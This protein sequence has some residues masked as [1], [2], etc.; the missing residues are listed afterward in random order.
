ML[1]GSQGVLTGN[2]ELVKAHVVEEHIDATEVVGG[3]VDFLSEIAELHTVPAQHLLCFQ[4]KGSGAAGRIID[5]VDPGFAHRAEPCQQLGNLGG[6]EEFP[7]GLTRVGGVH[8]H[9]I[10]IGVAE[11]VDAMLLHIAQ[12]HVRHTV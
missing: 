12:V 10:F 9:K 6:C 3:D 7:T 11:S 2:A 5:L 4:K 8:G 1:R